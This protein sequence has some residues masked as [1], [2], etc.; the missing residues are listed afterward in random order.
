MPLSQDIEM[1]NDSY[2]IAGTRI[3]LDS[4]A[5]A[6]RRGE[7]MDEILTDF[8]AIESRQKL[9]RA[10][11]FIEA[12]PKEI[13]SYL[14]Q[15]AQRWEEA[16]KLNPPDLVEKAQKYRAEKGLKSA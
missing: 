3:S 4:I 14:A 10:I 5:Y 15:N 7:T 6:V 2:Y 16:R 13:E 1:R 8:P 12:H 9:E 11:A